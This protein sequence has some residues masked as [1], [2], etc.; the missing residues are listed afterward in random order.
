M[1]SI[2]T[3]GNRVVKSVK[4]SKNH[5]LLE[6]LKSLSKTES[7]RRLKKDCGAVP[8]VKSVN[9]LRNTESKNSTDKKCGMVCRVKNS[10]EKI[11]S[12]VCTEVDCDNISRTKSEDSL[13]ETESKGRAR[14]DCSITTSFASTKIGSKVGESKGL[15]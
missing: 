13:E 15:K 6:W 8:K 3:V 14:K 10:S 9:S 11:E 12:R 5:L 7:K 2:T 1:S 4:T